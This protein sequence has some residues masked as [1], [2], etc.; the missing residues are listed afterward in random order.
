MGNNLHDRVALV[1]GAGS[2]IGFGRG[3]ALILAKEGCD[4]VV[5]DIN[6]EEAEN[7]ATAVRALGRKAVAIKA[8][9][10]G[11]EEVRAM[12]EQALEHFGRIDILVNNAGATYPPRPFVDTP[13]TDWEKVVNL[14][15]YGTLNCTKAVLPQMIERKN[16]RIV[17]IASGA[18]LGGSPGF[19]V[20]GASKGGVIAFTRGLAKE[21]IA[22][23]INVNCIAPGIGDTNFL[24]TA[25]F[26]PEELESVLS[27]V[28]SGKATTPDDIGHMVAFLASD[29]SNNIVGQTFIVDGGML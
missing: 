21:V 23:G 10:T 8:D 16:G 7:T 5:N 3:I 17:N 26:P 28:P 4:I 13:E 25:D 22:S 6:P 29:S 15:L 9:V 27:H 1:T 20:Y 19:V 14:N 2:P 12:V 11:K 18:G 24:R